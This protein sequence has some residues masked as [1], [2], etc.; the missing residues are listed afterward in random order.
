MGAP[1]KK[2]SA[3]ASCA[4]LSSGIC[5]FAAWVL[6]THPKLR[7][8]LGAVGDEGVAAPE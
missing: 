6:G 7:E 4:S 2:P 8:R 5:Q 3:S 1:S